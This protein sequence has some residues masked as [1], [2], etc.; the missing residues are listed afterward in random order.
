MGLDQYAYAV[1]KSDNN[2][3]FFYDGKR[4][5]NELSYWRKHPNLE[6]WMEKL[7]NS[8]AD[9]Q[10]HSG[11]KSVTD[12]ILMTMTSSD[13]KVIEIDS[14]TT[15]VE[16]MEEIMEAVVEAIKDEETR[17]VTKRRC[18]NNQ[19]IRLNISDLDQLEMYIKDGKLP[20][21]TGFFFGD[22]ADEEYREQDLKFINDARQAI[23][24]GYDVYYI[25]S[26]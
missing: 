4:I 25:S 19:P 2:D 20:P 12:K 11:H 16:G 10:G 14:N 5:I 9:R 23:S 17:R 13:G 3:D 21:T 24:N 22:G 6:G 18:F 8:K 7:Y 1:K 26:W 15:V